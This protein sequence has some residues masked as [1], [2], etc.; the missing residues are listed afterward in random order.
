MLVIFQAMDAAGKDSTIKHVF[1]GINPAGLRVVSFKRPSENE[2][3]HDF[4]WRTNLQLPERGTMTVFNRS[5]YEEVLVVKVHPN[6]ITDT[7]HLPEKLSDDLDE[8]FEKRYHDI[9]NLEKYLTNNGIEIVKFFLHVSKK[10]QAERLLERLEDPTKNWKF[11]A[12]D[13]NERALWDKYQKAYEKAINATATKHAPW[14]V[15][16]ADDKKNMRLLVCEVLKERLKALKMNY[17]SLS[18]E[19]QSQIPNYIQILKNEL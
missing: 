2:L 16:P 13:L 18:A 5:Y 14:Y 1:A 11:E 12:G 10:E 7:Q 17:P 3:D 15:I 19:E 4:L 6:I 8:L 9:A